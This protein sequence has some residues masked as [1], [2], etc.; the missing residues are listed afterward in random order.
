MTLEKLHT[1]WETDSQLDTSQL[2]KAMRDIPLLH[3]KW[4]RI[5]TTERQRYMTIK[6]ER[7]T[8]VQLRRDWYLGR[9]DDDERTKQNW[10]YQHLKLV[11][12]DV[13]VV[14]QSDAVIQPLT[15][16]LDNMELRLK[17]IEDCIKAINYRSNLVRTY[18]D[19]LK[20]SQ[21]S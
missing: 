8:M 12:Q 11:R 9:L 3:G 10:P 18:V 20:F 5:Y 21:G 15:L 16:K 4:W 2:D 1:E 19:Y 7:D 13:D 17:F 14:M 6:Q